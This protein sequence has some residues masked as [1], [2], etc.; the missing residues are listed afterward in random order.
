MSA[1]FLGPV[2]QLVAGVPAMDLVSGQTALDVSAAPDMSGAELFSAWMEL[3]QP[4]S[5]ADT[6]TQEPA[7][8]AVVWEAA[9]DVLEADVEDVADVLQRPDSAMS[10]WPGAASVWTQLQPT[11]AVPVMVVEAKASAAPAPALS[12]AET[13]R[14]RQIGPTTASLP[15]ALKPAAQSHAVVGLDVLDNAALMV[16]RHIPT[17][18]MVQPAGPSMAAP[19]AVPVHQGAQPLLE[20]LGQRIHLQQAQ[21]VDVATVRLDPPQMGSLEIRIRQEGAGVQVYIQ[22]SHAEV[23]RQLGMLVDSLRQELQQRSSDASVTV[24]QGRA[25]SGGGQGEQARREQPPHPKD[26]EIGQ[27][28]QAWP[29]PSLI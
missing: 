3:A 25:S 28:L 2:T 15:G 24:A 8:Q 26:S 6:G 22:A 10:A 20:A 9:L 23:G 21:G 19:A 7:P 12:V 18:R 14:A 1:M 17:E 13:A 16:A 5:E 11:S 27:A 29:H 4:E